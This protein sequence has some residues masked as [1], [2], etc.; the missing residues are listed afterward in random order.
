MRKLIFYAFLSA[1]MLVTAGCEK[2]LPTITSPDVT[3]VPIAQSVDIT[4]SYN[5]EA[6]FS[7]SE[8]S[9][10]GGTVVI[11]TD[12]T[13][14]SVSGN[15][16]VTFI[17]GSESGAGTVTHSIT[18]ENGNT[19]QS[20]AIL[21]IKKG[22]S[23]SSN[24]T[25]NTTWETGDIYILESRITVVSGVTLTIE[26]GVVVKGEAGTG[27]NATALLIARGATLNASGTATQ[28]IIFTSVSDDIV[29]GQ[30]AS[31]NLASD[32]DGLWGG[33]LILRNAP[34]FTILTSAG[35]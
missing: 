29:P 21:D 2:D 27:S 31:P 16:V 17:A 34:I 18:D 14:G 12:G 28:P 32:L 10:S 15:I 7:A 25:A 8:V 23:V 30:I 11:K 19:V 9:A 22:I 35:K 26:P 1:A 3:N 4:F 24:I 33:L 20:I 5:A 13:A 6:G